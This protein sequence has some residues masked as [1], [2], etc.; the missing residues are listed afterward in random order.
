[1][2]LTPY[3]TTNYGDLQLFAEVKNK[4]KQTQFSRRLTGICA[5]LGNFLIRTLA[6]IP[7]SGFLILNFRRRFGLTPAYLSLLFF[8]LCRA[9]FST[10]RP[11]KAYQPPQSPPAFSAPHQHQ[12]LPAD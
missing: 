5:N 7:H 12:R 11:I 10:V 3:Q 6:L 8:Q 9:I 1:M 2:N 4:P